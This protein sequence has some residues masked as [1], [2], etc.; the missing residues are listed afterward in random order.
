[1]SHVKLVEL[2]ESI[3]S[4]DVRKTHSLDWCRPVVKLWSISIEKKSRKMK[5]KGKIENENL[6]RITWEGINV[7]GN[8]A[9]KIWNQAACDWTFCGDERIG[10]RWECSVESNCCRLLKDYL[11]IVN[12]VRLEK[13]I[14]KSLK[15]NVLHLFSCWLSRGRGQTLAGFETHTIYLLTSFH[16]NFIDDNSYRKFS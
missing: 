6:R 16:V 1:M 8:D 13:S 7:R 15:G 3:F 12:V 11:A 4:K 14:I 10:H 9:R 2:R 5:N